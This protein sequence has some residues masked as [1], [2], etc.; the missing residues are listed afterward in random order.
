MRVNQLNVYIFREDLERLV[1]CLESS[2]YVSEWFYPIETVPYNRVQN[3]AELNEQKVVH[4]YSS[5]KNV[6][7]KYV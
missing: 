4:F 5:R 1:K 3:H 6:G 2:S 7:T